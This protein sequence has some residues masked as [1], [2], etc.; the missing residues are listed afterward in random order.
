MKNFKEYLFLSIA[1]TLLSVSVFLS[2][3]ATAQ[4]KTFTIDEA[5]SNGGGKLVP[6]NA[7]QLQWI[8]N[9][10]LYS[11]ADGNSFMIKEAKNSSLVKSVSKNELVVSFRKA[12]PD[13]DTLKKLPRITWLNAST[14]K[15]NLNNKIYAYDYQKKE[16]KFLAKFNP[17]EMENAD[18]DPTTNKVAYTVGNN[19]F[20]DGKQITFDTKAGFV[21]GQAVHRSEFGI[22]KGL[23]WNNDG[24]QL[25]FYHVDESMV[26]EYPIYELENRPA[27]ARTIRYPIAGTPSHHAVVC[28][29]YTSPSPRD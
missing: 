27:T 13:D 6:K 20:L 2:Y 7:D 21:N 10:S 3:S 26:A 22:T 4:D 8:A 9:S 14:F 15:Y 16:T 1:A 18:I 19:I 11:I 25:A 12:F 23:F 28:L 29:L 17:L 5:V 24:K